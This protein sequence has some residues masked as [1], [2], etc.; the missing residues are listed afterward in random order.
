[1]LY[2]TK[3]Q[4]NGLDIDSQHFLR[5]DETMLC[6]AAS[7]TFQQVRCVRSGTENNVER[8]DLRRGYT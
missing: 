5:D 6:Q 4:S 3:A 2:D 8:A 7:T 1:M